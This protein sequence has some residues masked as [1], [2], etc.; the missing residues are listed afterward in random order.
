MRIKSLLGIVTLASI[1]GTAVFVLTA[2]HIIQ[3]STWHVSTWFALTAAIV[4]IVCVAI[5]IGWGALRIRKSLRKLRTQTEGGSQEFM[6]TGIQELDDIGKLIATSAQ[7]VHDAAKADREELSAIKNLLAELDRR[8]GDF[9]RSGQPYDCSSRLRA[10]LKGYGG[11]LDS[12]VRQAIS[13]GQEIKRV[14]EELVTGSESQSDSVNQTTSFIEQMSTGLISVADVSQVALESSKSVENCVNE[15]LQQFH[16]LISE[17][18]QIRNHAAARERK[19]QALGK[20]TKH[21]ESI[22]QA[23][24]TLSSRTDLLALNASIESVRAGEHGRGFAVVADEVRALAEQSAQAVVDISD[25]IELI[26][27]ETHQSITIAKGEHDQMYQVI[28]RVDDTRNYL[29]TVADASA[30]SAAS[31]NQISDSTQRQLQLAQQVVETLERSSETSKKNRGRAEGALWTGKTLGQI[32]TQL[33]NSLEVFRSAGVLSLQPMT[34][35]NSNANENVETQVAV[36]Q[37]SD[38]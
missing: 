7:Q 8:Q 6:P 37:S 10:I 29:Q 13:C 3:A 28:K 33:E 20:H 19:L 5:A 1:F 30:E 24:G 21:I 14:A 2:S 36:A 38:Q 25:R 9:D 35:T 27:L 18:K 17:M 16:D 31:L 15:G 23:I 11:E 12:G 26:Q 22:V 32:G 4:S 34:Q